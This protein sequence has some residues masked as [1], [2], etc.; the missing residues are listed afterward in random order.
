[1]QDKISSRLRRTGAAVILLLAMNESAWAFDCPGSS[2]L[3]WI[4]TTCGHF[5]DAVD[6]GENNLM[7]PFYSH[8]GRG[9]YTAEKIS[10]YNEHTRGIG[11]ER[12]I[13]DTKGDWHGFFAIAFSD[14]HFKPEYAAGYNYQTYWGDSGSLQAGLGY[15]VFV[16]TRSDYDHYL[17]P[18][19]GLLPMASLRYRSFSLMAT[20]VPR[21][22]ANGGNGDVL[23]MFAR[24]GF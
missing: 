17:T 19:P 13:T 12:S 3:E 16:T 10:T 22:S 20:Y 18:V 6:R 8:H 11:Y 15:Q 24:I 2:L 4:K 14:S 23:F 21:L 5:N 1:M 7:L 9:T